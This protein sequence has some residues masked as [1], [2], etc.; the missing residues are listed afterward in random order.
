MRQVLAITCD[1]TLCNTAMIERLADMLPGFSHVH[2][3]LPTYCQSC[4]KVDDKII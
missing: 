3:I 2:K 4:G 1:N